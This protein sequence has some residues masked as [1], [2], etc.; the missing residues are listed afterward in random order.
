M[1]RALQQGSVWMVIFSTILPKGTFMLLI[2]IKVVSLSMLY[3]TRLKKSLLTKPAPQ[4]CN[5]RSSPCVYTWAMQPVAK[6][7]MQAQS[8]VTFSTESGI[9]SYDNIDRQSHKNIL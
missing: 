9:G 5:R 3:R 1:R 7:G 6:M 8:K 4:I 2:S